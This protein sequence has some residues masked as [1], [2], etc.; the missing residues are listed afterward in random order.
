MPKGPR[1]KSQQQSFSS[2][3]LPLLLQWVAETALWC[4]LWVVHRLRGTNSCFLVV[5][6][7][8]VKRQKFIKPTKNQKNKQSDGS[9]Q[10]VSSDQ[11]GG[12]NQETS[13]QGVQLRNQKW[14]KPTNTLSLSLKY[15]HNVLTHVNWNIKDLKEI[16]KLKK[17]LYRCSRTI[18]LVAQNRGL[19]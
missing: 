2:F 4:Q 17:M 14:M 1:I 13:S 11:N 8:Q 18:T 12:T 16:T 3:L 10:L 9:Q 7:T 6:C 19:L 15:Y 5:K